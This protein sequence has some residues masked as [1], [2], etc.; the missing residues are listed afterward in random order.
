MIR[1]NLHKYSVSAMCEVLQISRSTYY[2]EAKQQDNQEQELTKLI[3]Q[4]FKD[5][6][7][8]YGQRKIKVELRKLGWQV[9]RRR[10]SR[11]MKEQ[12]LLSKYTVAQFKPMKSSVNESETANVLNRKFNQEKELTVIVSD[13]TYVRVKQRWH[14]ICVLVDLYNREIIGYSSGP[15]KNAE[16][17]Q[18][19]FS[20]VPYNLNRLELFHTDRG[21]EFKN[22]FIDKALDAFGIKRSL[23]N[24]GTPYD[25]A[26]AEAT[27][28]T[29]KTEF[30]NG[31]VFDHQKE[32]DL[33][34]FDYVNWYNTIR[35][36]GSLGYLSPQE[37]K[38][39]NL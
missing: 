37:Y 28:K 30:I 15:N 18:R 2:Y 36:H 5:S 27:F 38:L 21:S 9:S 7:S 22:Q 24:K 20:T 26:V 3:V 32:L 16:L 13:L 1:N 25:N 33:E 19:A 29:I 17:V 10:I 8:I 6:H 31:R 23:S 39:S 14:Y 11:I 12:G 35:I 34:L 4:I